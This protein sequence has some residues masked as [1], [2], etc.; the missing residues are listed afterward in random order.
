MNISG[1]RIWAIAIIITIIIL[2]FGT[3]YSLGFGPFANVRTKLV[4]STTTS[5]YD[6][7]LLDIIEDYFESNYLIDIYFI[8]AGTNSAI[9]YAQKGDADMILVHAPSKEQAFLEDGYGVCRKIIAY[10][11]FTI[12]GPVEDPIKIMGLSPTQALVKIVDAGRRGEVTWVSRGDDSGTHSKEKELWVASG[13]D[14]NKLRFEDQWFRESGT[15]MGKTLQIANEFSAYTLADIGTYL[16]YFSD[17]LINLNVLVDSRREL[18]NV[19][20]VIA[21][22]QTYN[23]EV[24]FDAAI[25]FIKFLTSDVGQQIIDQFG[26]EKYSQTLFYPAVQLLDE[27]MDQTLVNWIIEFAYFN[28]SE[29]PLKY[30]DDHKEMYS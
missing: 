9:Q 25:T 16:K 24:N 28:G 12:I 2:V 18:L 22:N 3:T 19:Y 17:Q 27:K 20:S 5:L 21:V 14:W 8:S 30:Q 10:N 11:F 15:G 1:V 7:G 26:Q 6:T 29:C 23:P 4:V 13:F